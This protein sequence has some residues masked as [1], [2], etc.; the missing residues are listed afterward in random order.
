MGRGGKKKNKKDGQGDGDEP[1]PTTSQEAEVEEI[2]TA[3]STLQV[4]ESA[5]AEVKSEQKKPQDDDDDEG[6]LGL[7]SSKPRKKRKPKSQAAKPPPNPQQVPGSQVQ[8]GQPGPE[9]QVPPGLGQPPGQPPA[10][11]QGPPGFSP[12]SGPPQFPGAPQQ[13]PRGPPQQYPGAP[14]QYLG[15]PQQYPGAPQPLPGAPQQYPGAP[16]QYLGAPQQYPGAPQPLPEAPQQYP[17]APQQFPGAPQQYPGAPQQY[18][19]A[20]QQYPGAPQQSPGAPLQSPGAHPFHGAARQR[21]T[22]PQPFSGAA[23]Q[24]PGAPQQYPGVPQEAPGAPQQYPGAPQGPGAQQF[25][26]APQQRPGALQQRPG[27]PQQRPGA[28]QQ[29]PQQTGWGRGQSPQPSPQTAGVPQQRPQQT[30]WGRGQSPQP[31]PQTAAPAQQQVAQRLPQPAP[32]VQPSDTATLHAKQPTQALCRFQIP[33][34]IMGEDLTSQRIKVVTNYLR[35]QFKDIKIHRYDVNVK[36]DKPKK[37]MPKVFQQVKNKY[38]KD[39]TIAFDQTKNMFTLKLITRSVTDTLETGVEVLD[40][41]NAAMSFQVVIKHTGVIDLSTISNYMRKGG[42]TLE[43]P[44]EAIQCIDVILQQGT[45]GNYVKAGRQYFRRPNQPIDLTYGMEMWTGL[46]QSAVFNSGAYINIDVAHKGFP[47]QQTI[48]QALKNDFNLDPRRDLEGQRGVEEFKHF[49]KGLRVTALIGGDSKSGRKREFICNEIVAPPSKLGF[50]ITDDKGQT[51]KC[52]VEKYFEITK[53]YRLQYPNLNCIW[54]GPRDKNIY[55]PMEL[56]EVVYGQPINKQ[57]SDKQLPIMVKEAATFP[58]IRIKKIHEVIQNMKYASNPQ[59]KQFGLNIS[60]QL[61]TIDA[62]I[63]KVPKLN[64]GGR[65]YIEPRRGAWQAPGLLQAQALHKWAIMLVEGNPSFTPIPPIVDMMISVGRKMGMQIAQPMF[66]RE[67][68]QIRDLRN[69]LHQ[70]VDKG[71]NFVVVIITNRDR[72]AYHKVKRTAELDVGVLTQCIKDFTANR[73]MNEQT[74]RNILLKIN[75]KLMG[76]NQALEVSSL[77][78]CLQGGDVMLVGADVTHPSPDQSSVPSIAAVTASIDSKYFLY[79]IE[80]SVQTPKKEMIMQFEDMMV[81]HLQ[82]YK[83]HNN[84]RLPKKVYVLRDGVSDGQFAEVMNSELV[85]LHNAFKR[86][87]I[88]KPEIL[89]LLVQKRHHTRLFTTRH[90]N[91]EPGTVVDTDIVHQTELNFYLVS[92]QAIKGT[93]RPTRYHCVC[94]DGKLTV[95]EVEQLAFYLCHLYS[96]CTRS[97]SYPTPTY[98]AHLACFR[99]RSLTFGDR[100]NNADLERNPKRIHVMDRMLKFSRMFFV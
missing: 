27:A 51:M 24:A 88:E 82:V 11:S 19:G 38:F 22:T 34:K 36:P 14:Q 83:Q 30:G 15:A 56:L 5:T 4:T 28:P 79:N 44:M 74:M 23:Q 39:H 63:L 25:P 31:S 64:C 43:M 10:F 13:Y 61:T 73:K 72:D 95:S 42:S 71:V 47:K 93:A 20:P 94:N 66:I 67:S 45:L 85:A 9:H 99:A 91:V 68:L 12:S 59:F 62:K 98:Y 87:A 92:H 32:A 16:H 80:L 90:E 26:G 6:G 3:T 35:M 77:P 100:F 18:P 97:V 84:G 96:R 29:R 17:G 33:R 57:L 52:T 89:F 8:S 65:N 46:F 60:D 1:K 81:D 53:K 70:M 41:N 50:S 58:N 69:T 48:L 21:P 7:G 76:V 54:V 40:D 2:T 86:F 55:Y 49:L 37:M 75:S 78:K